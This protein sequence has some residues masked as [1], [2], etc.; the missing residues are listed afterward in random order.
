MT[1]LRRL[2]VAVMLLTAPMLASSAA[3][4]DEVYEG[5]VNHVIDANTVRIG[6]HGGQI[7]IRL[8]AIELPQTTESRDVLAE[9][10]L[11]KRVQVRGIK[12]RDGIL[13]GQITATESADNADLCSDIIEPR[14]SS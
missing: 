3:D 14:N 9:H 4:A 2:F 8:A 10:L 6:Y 5:M 11:G 7:R 12:W 1:I 13:I